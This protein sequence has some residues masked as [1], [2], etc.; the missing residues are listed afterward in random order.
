MRI[1][2]TIGDFNGVGPE[3]I[4]NAF[5]RPGVREIC[6]PVIYGAPRIFNVYR[7]LMSVDKFSY[8]VIQTP[9]QAQPRRVS[10]I[11]CIDVKGRVE[12]GR[13]DQDSGMA[14]FQALEAA[15]KDLKEG[16]IDALV[17]MP[18]DKHYIQNENFSF[19]G[20]TEYLA[21][22]FEVGDNL[23]FMVHD[24]L[25][26]GV[27]TGHVPIKEVSKSLSVGKII[28]KIQMMN[29]SLKF[30][31]NLEKP[32]IAVLGLNPHAGD[33]GLLG[34]EEQ[35][36]IIKAVE[37]CANDKIFVFGPYSADGFFASGTY[38][39]F[40]GILAM[41][42]DQGLIPFKL[43]AGFEGVNFTAGLPAVRTSPDH[44]P[45][46]DLVGKDKASPD[47]FIHSLYTAIDVYRRRRENNDLHE[48]S[49]WRSKQ[50][51]ELEVTE[52]DIV[53]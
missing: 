49:I 33:N 24:L 11:D 36:I 21:E 43:L 27:V 17:T 51:R 45:A 6:T 50:K 23:M 26:V 3:L 44:G 22:A 28:S 52:E 31:F 2:I 41:Y 13:P 40:D 5:S 7:K 14:A 19:P 32:R 25:R 42:H 53:E 16:L 10:V 35:E 34:S 18:I 1:G 37:K 20:H 48:N 12:P 9:D 8:N 46:F 4:I 47:S 39:K 15:T 30:D 38:R 29:H